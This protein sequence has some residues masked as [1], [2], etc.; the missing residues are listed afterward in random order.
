MIRPCI[1]SALANGR[2][3]VL[4][5]R[6]KDWKRNDAS[7]YDRG[8]CDGINGLEHKP[9]LFHCVLPMQAYQTKAPTFRPGLQ[10]L[11]II[12]LVIKKPPHRGGWRADCRRRAS[13]VRARRQRAIF[14]RMK[15]SAATRKRNLR[16]RARLKQ[17]AYFHISYGGPSGDSRSAML[18]V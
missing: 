13:G 10:Q 5:F 8:C 3:S 2:F 4:P 15:P 6:G 16:Y 12:C 7:P 9:F 14:Y 18:E 17:G 1:L 11:P